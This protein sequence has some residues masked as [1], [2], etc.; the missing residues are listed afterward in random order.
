MS[1]IKWHEGRR[2]AITDCGDLAAVPKAARKGDVVCIFNGGRVPYV[3]RP[4]KNGHYTL[5]GECY[6]DGMMRGEV[7]DRFPRKAHETSFSIE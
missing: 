5:V 3:L 4:S 1:V 2:F 7:R 6:V